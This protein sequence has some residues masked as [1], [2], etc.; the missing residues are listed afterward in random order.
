MTSPAAKKATF[1]I[2]LFFLILFP[3]LSPYVTDHA[4]MWDTWT[5]RIFGLYHFVITQTL[6]IVHEA[7]HGV[8]YLLP[9]PKVLTAA[10]GTIFQVGFPL[11]VAWYYQRK[12]NRVAVYIAR[13]FAGFSLQYTAWYI[14]TAHEG[15]YVPASKSFLGVD[16]YHDFAY[17]LGTVGLVPY[18]GFLS[19]LIKV[20]AYGIMFWAVTRMYL[21]AFFSGETP[22]GK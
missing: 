21:E 14:S 15:L 8:C 17:L 18:D 4:G 6:G 7:G 22:A 2:F 19:T 20:T 1:F 11:L 10:N 3:R 16:G 5:E 9:C 13:F 12:E